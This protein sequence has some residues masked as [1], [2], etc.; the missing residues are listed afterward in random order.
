MIF[1]I[2]AAKNG[3]QLLARVDLLAG[4]VEDLSQETPEG[5]FKAGAVPALVAAGIDENEVVYAIEVY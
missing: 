3:D 5:F 2:Y 1:E 4:R